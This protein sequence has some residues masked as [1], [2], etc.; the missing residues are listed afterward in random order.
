MTSA[1]LLPLTLAAVAL[2]LLPLPLRLPRRLE[3]A[4]ARRRTPS[5]RIR[6]AATAAVGVL[7]VE[8]LLGF[9]PWWL[10]SIVDI[11]VYTVTLRLPMARTTV[12]R[13]VDRHWLAV[14]A[15]LVAA[16]LDAGMSVCSALLAVPAEQIRGPSRRHDGEEDP[17]SIL[18]AVAALLVLGADADTAWRA[19]QAHPDLASLAAAARRSAAGGATLAEAVREHAVDLRALN[20][21]AAE[22]SAGRAGV[23]M[24]APL[25]LCFLP[26]FV[27]LG[28]APVVLGLLTTL[29]LF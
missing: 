26:A 9:S 8:L 16:C 23:A 19:A 1:L 4:A 24:T 11:G 17:F 7:A 22:R 13:A 5:P 15:D 10:A 6:S 29:K 20:A 25:A 27:C 3:P 14:H 12:G 2:E 28:L 21:A 18:D